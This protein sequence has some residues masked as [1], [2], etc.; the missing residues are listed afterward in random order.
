[1]EMTLVQKICVWA[2][3]LI[4]AITLHEVAHGWVASWCGDQTA[5]L[6]KRLS[7]NPLHHIDPIGT[8]ILPLMML[9]TTN[10]VFGWAKPVPIDS[11]N[12]R[13]PRRDVILVALAGPISNILMAIFWAAIMRWALGMNESGNLWLGVP[14]ALMGQAG[15]MI[16]IVVAVINL[17]PLPPL[18]G[19]RVLVNLLPPRWGYQLS[20]IEPYSF[21]ILIILM[22]T[23][24]LS[25]IVGPAVVGF[26]SALSTLFG[27]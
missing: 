17:I 27:F 1:M 7:L 12:M 5:R 21:V 24:I 18:D 23:G 15:I 22:V 19:G 25:V 16:N 2:I 4:F 9:L 14:L 8:V 20:L 13:H 10:F 11:R 3:P 26:Y 6:S